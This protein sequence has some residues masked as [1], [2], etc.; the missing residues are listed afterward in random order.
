MPLRCLLFS[1][2]EAAVAAILE[3]LAALGVQAEHCKDAVDAVEKVTTHLF[4]IVITD[5]QDQPEASF[6]LKTARDLK[7]A[8]RPLTLAIVSEEARPLALQAGANSILLRPV[9]PEQVRDTMSTACQLLQSKLQAG[10]PVAPGTSGVPAS[11]AVAASGG[12]SGSAAAAAPAPVSVAQAPEKLRAGDFLQSAT[13]APGAQFD[14]EK[15]VRENMEA[16]AT[17][18]DPLTELEPMAAAVQDAP[19]QKPEPEV[20]LSGW[21]ALQARLTKSTPLPTKDPAPKNEIVSFDDVANS[22]QPPRQVS[23]A[24]PQV[25]PNVSSDAQPPGEP[26]GALFD[27][28]EGGSKK[29]DS[30]SE[31]DQ[32]RSLTHPGPPSKAAK[33]VF[34]GALAVAI[35]V[36]AGVPRV[37]K[38]AYIQYSNGMHAGKRWLNPPPAALPPTVTQHDSFGQPGDEYKLPTVTSIPDSTTDASQIQVVPVVDP[39]AK[40]DKHAESAAAPGGDQN[41]G[42]T[43]ASGSSDQIPAP[44]VQTASGQV[45][46]AQPKGEG[47]PTST[48]VP[49]GTLP[50][51]AP[52]TAP[53]AQPLPVQQA[54][55]SSAQ[56]V[57]AAPASPTLPATAP[58]VRSAAPPQTASAPANGGIPTSLR[59]VTAS[60]IPDSSG[61]KPPD[62][63]MSSIEPVKL[64]ESVV[65]EQLAPGQSADPEYP[66][67][68][69]ASGQSG[70]VV[71]QVLIGRDGTVQDAKFLQGSFMF[72]RAAIDAVRQWHFKPYSLNGHPVSVQGVIT[73]NFKPPSS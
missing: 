62:A 68:A 42:A 30:N 8:V 6:L 5:W 1:S 55:S 27:Y 19:E 28:I 58:P 66:A 63:A 65:R 59:S 73:L 54:Q 48:T 52:I 36:V 37:R 4:Q 16:P 15:D 39:T 7:A 17:E 45:V 2:D 53:A 72:A 13:T 51:V 50:T 34:L 33:F 38:N 67:A 47:S 70:S 32:A 61:T 49:A 20:P 26:E 71:L 43:T 22:V 44:P 69:K 57:P 11:I 25:S 24:A 29:R 35:V 21:A 46:S 64:P 3:V 12:S 23:A 18:V 14:T 31:D 41:K 56:P 40:P 10:A 60:T 9:R